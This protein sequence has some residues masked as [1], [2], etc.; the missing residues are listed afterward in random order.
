MRLPKDENIEYSAA[1]SLA[2]MIRA[3]V[4][5]WVET[6]DEPGHW[7]WTDPDEDYSGRYVEVDGRSSDHI[8]VAEPMEGKH[9]GPRLVAYHSKVSLFVVLPNMVDSGDLRSAMDAAVAIDALPE[10]VKG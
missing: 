5:G 10:E 7:R 2:R 1:G 8:P 3:R 6:S 9:V 4:P